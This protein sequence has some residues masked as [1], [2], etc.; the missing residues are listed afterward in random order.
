[1]RA[2]ARR[3]MNRSPRAGSFREISVAEHRNGGFTLLEV[4]VA[5]AILGLSLT[6]ILSSQAGLFSSAARAGNLTMAIPLARCRME[7]TELALQKFGLPLIDQNDSGPCCGDED[8]PG[9]NC[10][11]KI[12][13][14]EL[15]EANMADLDL[16][17]DEPG[18][19]GADIG[20][21]DS[22]SNNPLSALSKLQSEPDSFG[23]TEGLGEL[24][25][26]FGGGDGGAG[27]TGMILGM[28]YPDLKPMLEAS[29]R[30]V[31]VT[32]KWR[33]GKND[34][35]LEIAQYVTNPL[36]GGFDPN[37]AEGMEEADPFGAQETGSTP[38]GSSKSSQGEGR[39]P[40]TASNRS[41]KGT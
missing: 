21:G 10:E 7:A 22:K 16:G 33:E 40:S 31:T 17:M 13:T 26:M 9:F 29:I 30:K 8:A 5:I 34:R 3:M 24:A 27:L 32:V 20:A 12:E 18:S 28:V 37:A 36:Q 19:I 2:F 14:I 41:G 25:G 6:V 23:T 35:D 11:W 39:T 38:T 15:P 1:M 4:M